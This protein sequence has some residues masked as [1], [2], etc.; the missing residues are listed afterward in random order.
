M[1]LKGVKDSKIDKKRKKKKKLKA[2]PEN[3]T[4]GDE[5]ETAEA[6]TEGEESLGAGRSGEASAPLTIGKTEAER[7]H[8]EMKRKRVCKRPWP[9]LYWHKNAPGRLTASVFV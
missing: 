1:K 4:A 7:R 6:T 5:A 2:Q 8:E 3:E 9:P